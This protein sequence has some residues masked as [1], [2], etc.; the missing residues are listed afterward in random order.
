MTPFGFSLAHLQGRI[1]APFA[2]VE[3]TGD[4]QRQREKEHQTS[5]DPLLVVVLF[6]VLVGLVQDSVAVFLFQLQHQ[7]L[8]LFSVTE[9]IISAYCLAYP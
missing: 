6:E 9:S 3:Q 7:I 8:L 5:D 4:Q 1:L 2:Q